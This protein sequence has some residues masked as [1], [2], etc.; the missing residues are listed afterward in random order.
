M[1]RHQW[2]GDAATTINRSRGH[3]TPIKSPLLFVKHSGNSNRTGCVTGS[4][5]AAMGSALGWHLPSAKEHLGLK[6]HLTR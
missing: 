6:G 5:S 4:Y 1:L 3:P 2:E